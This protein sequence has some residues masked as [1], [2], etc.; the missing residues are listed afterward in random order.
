MFLVKDKIV[1]AMA[2]MRVLSGFIE[3]TAAMLMLKF[4]RIETAVKI[5]AAL[6]LVGPVVMII[7]TT[8]GLVG[9]AGKVSPVRVAMILTG[10]TLIFAGMRKV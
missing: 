10:V 2:L 3:L 6:A 4:D 7:V 1:V 9:L 8:I 5:N